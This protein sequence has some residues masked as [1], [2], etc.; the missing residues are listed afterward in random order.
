MEEC[1][2]QP[3]YWFESFSE[4]NKRV[5]EWYR[6]F[7]LNMERMILEKD[8]C[9]PKIKIEIFAKNTTKNEKIDEAIAVLKMGTGYFEG[10]KFVNCWKSIEVMAAYNGEQVNGSVITINGDYS[11]FSHL[12]PLLVGILSEEISITSKIEEITD[13]MNGKIAFVRQKPNIR[14]TIRLENSSEVV[15]IP[16]NLNTIYGNRIEATIKALNWAQ[17]ERRTINIVPVIDLDEDSP[18]IALNI[19]QMTGERLWGICCK[20][21][22]KGDVSTTRLKEIRETLDKSF[23]TW[24]K[25]I[26][27]TEF[28]SDIYRQEQVNDL[29]AFERE[30]PKYSTRIV[31]VN[32]K[33]RCKSNKNTYL[34]K[35]S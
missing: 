19:A 34:K 8:D 6:S 20:S 2:L 28:S 13:V 14:G 4:I 21:K 11:L 29:Y 33:P 5:E 25:I 15:M 18:A 1:R 16:C 27:Q 7:G 22:F 3:G 31:S 35:V 23:F 32:G 10:N 9:H 12:V 24:I 17:K 30:Q 26:L